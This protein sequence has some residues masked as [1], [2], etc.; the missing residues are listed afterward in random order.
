MHVYVAESFFLMGVGG[1]VQVHKVIRTAG[2]KALT[3]LDATTLFSL[4]CVMG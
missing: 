4:V 3:W 1:G 2:H